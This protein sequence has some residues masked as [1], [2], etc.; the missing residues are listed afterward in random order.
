MEKRDGERSEEREVGW[1]A[2][3]GVREGGE[4]CAQQA[5]GGLGRD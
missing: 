1:L 5:R 4:G 2:G 3:Q